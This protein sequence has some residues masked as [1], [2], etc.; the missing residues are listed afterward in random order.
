MD[1]LDVSYSDALSEELLAYWLWKSIQVKQSEKVDGFEFAIQGRRA[2][3]LCT[4]G[5]VRPQQLRD[6]RRVRSESIQR[7]FVFRSR[8]GAVFGGSEVVPAEVCVSGRPCCRIL[9]S[10]GAATKQIAGFLS[11]GII[12]N[13]LPEQAEHNQVPMLLVNACA[14][15]LNDLGAEPFEDLKFELLGRIITQVRGRVQAS[16]HAVGAH[17]LV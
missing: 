17:D 2:T 11:P 14:P 13:P 5:Q 16:L 4:D 7:A 8:A 6:F 3:D 10:D 1:A 12:C 9:R 15:E